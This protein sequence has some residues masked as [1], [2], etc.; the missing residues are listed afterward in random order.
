MINYP[1]QIFKPVQNAANGAASPATTFYYTQERTTISAVY[2]VGNIIKGHLPGLVDEQGII[3][4]NY[5][6]VQ[7]VAMDQR[8]SLGRKFHH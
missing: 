7:G 4:M 3:R 2:A 1:N 5:K 8:R 6:T